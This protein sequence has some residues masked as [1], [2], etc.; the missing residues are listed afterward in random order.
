MNNITAPVLDRLIELA[1]MED[2]STTGDVTSQAIFTADAT[3]TA[4][5]KSKEH[6][7]LAGSYCIEPVYK[8]IESRIA[9][10]PLLQDGAVVDC[11]SAICLIKGPIRGILSGERIALN[12]IQHLSGIATKTFEMVSLISHTKALLLDTRK[13]APGFRSLEKA[14]VTA[15]GGY[16]HRMGLFDLILIKDTHVKAAG[17]PAAAI[18]KAKSFCG[19]IR[20]IKIEVEVQTIGQFYDALGESPDI[21]MLDNMSTADMKKC[22]EYIL[23]ENLQVKLEASGKINEKT[24]AETA[25]SGVDYISSGAI[26][27]SAPA[28]DIHLE[29]A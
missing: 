19:E 16:N 5:I 26:T 20:Q 1:V 8:K 11:E 13:T 22:C 24:I 7:V 2:L 6:G 3:A 25:E 28:L 29:I 18:K 12:F 17:G 10:K 21:I 23:K 27:H 15:G 4:V 9:V 14:A